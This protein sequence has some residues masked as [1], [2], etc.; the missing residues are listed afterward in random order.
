MK[1]WFWALCW[2]AVG[3]PG[4]ALAQNL[5]PNGSFETF[6][7]C[8]TLDNL[9]EEA[10]PWYNPNR[11]TPD[12]YHRCFPTPA[13]QLA[14]RTGQG[15]ARIFLDVG[16]AE[17][18]AVPLKEPLKAG[19]C[20]FF[21][22]YVAT[23]QPRRYIRD[24]FGAHLSREPV[25]STDKILLGVRPQVLDTQ[26]NANTPLRLLQWERVAGYVIAGGNERY[27]T[28]G[29]FQT[30]PATQ[31][32]SLYY[33]FVDDVSL[34]PV[35][36]NLGPDT[37][38]CGRTS[39]VRLRATTPG[40]TSYRWN[41]GSTDSTLLVTKPGTYAVTVFTGCKELRDTITVNYS[42]DFDLGR[43]TTL[44]N[45]QTLGLT[46]P[47]AAGQYRWQDGTG[48]PNYLV[49]EPGQYIVT[50]T[51]APC[52]VRDTVRVRYVPPPR[53]DL[54]LDRDLCRETL[55]TL[56]PD[57]AE[58]RFS[59][60]DGPP[61][62]VREVINSGV[63]RASVV[64]ECATLRDSVVVQREACPCTFYT[65]DVFTPN[66]DGLNDDFAPV[67]SCGDIALK[68]LTVFNRWGE[69]LFRADAPPFR[70]D[71]RFQNQTLPGG[72]YAWKI[73]FELRTEGR[74][75]AEWRQGAVTLVR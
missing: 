34:Q 72:V 73:G 69:V 15:L 55:V 28:I 12:F 65:P 63:Y 32:T 33:V 44:C 17:Y 29:S 48:G 5:V 37:T 18:L 47:Q 7:R 30:L 14:P 68:S 64:S 51:Q 21:E 57:F 38:L 24:T 42:L 39:T 4:P 23:D 46:V 31:A 9:L 20:Y 53:L 56:R 50:V 74:P 25:T 66:G 61:D 1:T 45:G 8:P 27:L 62:P 70:W 54:G 2:L 49:R 43:D 6:R 36:M 3:L 19:E 75:R 67:E 16:W 58:G 11:A 26:L 41:T 60:D 10:P 40:A 35:R 22:M 13:L 52:V 71:G 59:W